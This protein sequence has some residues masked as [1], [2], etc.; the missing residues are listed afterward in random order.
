MS[1]VF[2]GIAPHGDEIIHELNP[3]MDEKTANLEKAMERFADLL[4]K[5][6][7]ETIVLATPHNLRLYAHIGIIATQFT[8]GY[9][10]SNDKTLYLKWTCDRSFSRELYTLAEMCQLPVILVNYGTDEG[11]SSSMCMD[12]GTFIPLWF[13]KKKYEAEQK[14]LPK[15]VIVTPSREIPQEQLVKLGELIVEKS[16]MD[17][18]QVAFIASAD[19]GHAHDP[20]G[21]Y[22]YNQAS[23]EYDSLIL[24][25]VKENRLDELLNFSKKFIED[26]KPDSYWQLLI[27]LGVLKKSSLKLRLTA[28]ECP[29]YF[30]MLVA[31][32]I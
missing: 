19:Q 13:I 11:E 7:P 2:A 10:K 3:N 21:P 26:A 12:W 24:K 17:D 25:L 5:S 15:V 20:N 30:G 23:E 18:K 6:N 31:A 29:T 27:L 14:D 22:G 28:Y 9:L 1:I 8:E 4:F 16:K 32:Y